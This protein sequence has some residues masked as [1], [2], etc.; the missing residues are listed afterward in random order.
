MWTDGKKSPT[1]HNNDDEV[2]DSQ[3]R[4]PVHIITI[5]VF[6]VESLKQTASHSIGQL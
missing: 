5:K 4:F 3:A 1:S 2:D 6:P